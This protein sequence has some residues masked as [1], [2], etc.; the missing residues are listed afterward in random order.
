M[1]VVAGQPRVEIGC[2]VAVI[3]VERHRVDVPV[4]LAHAPPEALEAATASATFAAVECDLETLHLA[5][6]EGADHQFRGFL[7]SIIDGH[8]EAATALADSCYLQSGSPGGLDLDTRVNGDDALE[9]A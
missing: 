1:H 7:R 6:V 4:K 2:S 5:V 3:Q 8:L 9:P